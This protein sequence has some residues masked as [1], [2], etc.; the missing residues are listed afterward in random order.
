MVITHGVVQPLARI[1]INKQER[2]VDEEWNW[3]IFY[4]NNLRA[5]EINQLRPLRDWTRASESSIRS[6]LRWL[7]FRLNRS[8]SRHSGLGTRAVNNLENDPPPLSDQSWN[9]L[10][11]EMHGCLITTRAVAQMSLLSV[12]MFTWSKRGK[13][14]Q[15]LMKRFSRILSDFW[16]SL[17]KLLKT[18]VGTD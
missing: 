3:S 4:R 15:S 2:A 1:E 5:L 13:F 10:P 17:R 11:G 16:A 9:N 14:F 6:S 8:N 12:N 18:L 7:T